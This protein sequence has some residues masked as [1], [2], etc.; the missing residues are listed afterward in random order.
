MD[1]SLSSK[2]HLILFLSNA[3]DLMLYDLQKL[4]SQAKM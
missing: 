4:L 2:T 3:G 1:F